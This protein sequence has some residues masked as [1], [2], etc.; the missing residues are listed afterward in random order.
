MAPAKPGEFLG[1]ARGIGEFRPDDSAC[2]DAW[3]TP[4][5]DSGTDFMNGGPEGS[6]KAGSRQATNKSKVPGG[7]FVILVSLPWGLS[8]TIPFGGRAELRIDLAA[9]A[10]QEQ[11]PRSRSDPFSAWASASSPRC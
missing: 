2:R 3:T 11:S 4:K 6:R 9:R 1:P 5:I 8:W 7:G 10:T